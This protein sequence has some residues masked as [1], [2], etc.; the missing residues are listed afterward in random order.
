MLQHELAHCNGWMHEPFITIDP[1]ARFIHP[2]AGK[3]EVTTCGPRHRCK[4]VQKLCHKL[5]RERGIDVSGY[6]GQPGWATFN[7]CSITE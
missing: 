6:A 7:G 2:F 1:P 4:S 5:W 3:T